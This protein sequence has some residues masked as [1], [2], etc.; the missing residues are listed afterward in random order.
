MMV[1]VVKREEY[2]RL[3][4]VDCYDYPVLDWNQVFKFENC[5]FPRGV[6]VVRCV[7]GCVFVSLLLFS[8]ATRE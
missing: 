7:C 8:C 1:N 6:V 2:A 3:V 5:C 4:S